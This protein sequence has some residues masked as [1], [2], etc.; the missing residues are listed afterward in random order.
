MELM[1]ARCGPG[2]RAARRG[3]GARPSAC[4]PSC[5][6]CFVA[7]GAPALLSCC[8]PTYRAVLDGVS[9]LSFHFHAK[10]PRWLSKATVLGA[11]CLNIGV[12]GGRAMSWRLAEPEKGLGMLSA[13]NAVLKK[14]CV[15]Q[16]S[17][18]GFQAFSLDLCQQG[19]GIGFCGFTLKASSNNR[20]IQ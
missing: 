18:I 5:S 11:L 9:R 12:W 6:A 8:C 13:T 16:W 2:R 10:R 4:A 20:C 3:G 17:V 19:Y 7:A 14:R 1:R 15:L